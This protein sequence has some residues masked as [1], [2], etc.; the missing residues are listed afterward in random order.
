MIPLLHANQTWA[1]SKNFVLKPNHDGFTL[2]E[3]ITPA[4]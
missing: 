4:Q 2:P 1:M 3:G